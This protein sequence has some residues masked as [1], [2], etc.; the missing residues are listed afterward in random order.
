MSGYS[1]LSGCLNTMSYG[2]GRF[3]FGK[4]NPK[5]AHLLMFPEMKT[6]LNG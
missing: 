6:T 5:E 1:Y 2:I 3:F 4:D